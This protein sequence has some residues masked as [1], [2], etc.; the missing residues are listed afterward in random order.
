MWAVVVALL[1]GDLIP[2]LDS[3]DFSAEMQRAAVTATVRITCAGGNGSGVILARDRGLFVYVLT[4]NHVVAKQDGVEVATFST[5]SYPKEAK[6]Y[7]GTIVAR[8]PEK[9]LALVRLTTA[10]K[11]PSLVAFDPAQ[12][13]PQA[14]SAFSAL[15]VGCAEAEAP[16]CRIEKVKSK[17]QIKRP[18]VKE[19]VWAWEVAEAPRQGRSGGP[20]LDTKGNLIGICSGVGDGRGYYC[21]HEEIL[22][23]LKQ[24]AFEYLLT[25]E[26]AK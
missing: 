2:I 21:H 3:K 1:L 14:K 23:F 15:A 13:A 8:S 16:T 11:P 9:D 5:I 20:L 22:Q 18:G 4:A 12:A 19:A 26:G 6:T 17:K 10:D 25:K 24:N 7:S